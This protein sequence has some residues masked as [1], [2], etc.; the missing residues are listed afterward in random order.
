MTGERSRNEL[1]EAAAQRMVAAERS[2]SPADLLA[3]EEALG[4]LLSQMR[5]D[6]VLRAKVQADI[7][8][9]W[10][11]QW[12][13]GLRPNG[14]TDAIELL[15]SVVAR[16][17]PFRAMC[18]ANLGNALLTRG[19]VEDVDEMVDAFTEAVALTPPGAPQRA[20]YLMNLGAAL[21]ARGRARP[22]SDDV[23]HAIAAIGEAIALE[24]ADD[25]RRA[26][27]RANLA[28]ALR[29]RFDRDHDRGDIDRAVE[30]ARA[31]VE[32]QPSAAT[33]AIL[34]AALLARSTVTGDDVE[35]AEAVRVL[36]GALQAT[37]ESHAYRARRLTGL[38]SAL[39]R[40]AEVHDDPSDLERAEA[41]LLQAAQPASDPRVLRN[42]SSVV[43]LRAQLT[44]DDNLL[45]RGVAVARRIGDDGNLAIALHERG[46]R[47][48][49]LAALD[50]A[51]EVAEA[52]VAAAEPGSREHV[53]A[54]ARLAPIQQTRYL[55]TG[56]GADLDAAVM[57][58]RAAVEG[59][60]NG[61][62]ELPGRLSNLGNALRLR[63]ARTRSERDL[64]D[65]VRILE[66]AVEKAVTGR[67][68]HLSNLGAALQS[69]AELAG[70]DPAAAVPVLLAAVRATPASAPA[71]PRYLSNLGNALVTAGDPDGAV[72]RH[73][74]ALALLPQGH[75]G[76]AV[77][78]GNL[79]AALNA[80]PGAVA[81]DEVTDATRE[82]LA[83]TTVS[84]P[85]RLVAAWRLA[86]LEVRAAGG[87]TRQAAATMRTAVDLA[88]EV[89]W[90][91]AAP[92]DR[93]YTLA[94]FSTLGLDAAATVVDTDPGAAVAMLES[95]RSV[96]WSDQLQHRR[97]E[98]LADR[99]PDLAA[100]LRE[101]ATALDRP[102]AG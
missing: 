8:A 3:A 35:L 77:V 23:D 12:E 37:P 2:G 58:A 25:P 100:R 75:P 70:G 20:P 68:G 89:A 78:W 27:Y 88:R 47:T 55:R 11:R 57:A 63:G 82:V 29:T 73:R 16:P 6:D 26:A 43:I 87:D 60:R 10:R 72:A 13:R 34:G 54:L 98:A 96:G 59:S 42:L 52:V 101:V 71:R 40:R 19:D 79:A 94:R 67:V 17:A 33:A 80:L 5:P 28:D 61:D 51:V 64:D 56:R 18:L 76:R 14:L 1:V 95:G 65:A 66:Q 7:G 84:G 24:Q 30:A 50:E 92:G 15:R 39:R 21:S 46:A 36:V 102:L 9:V 86:D 97:V 69:R 44:G 41:L 74:E 99:S 62:P 45:D 81:L 91:G 85:D 38:A 48:G 49:D 22:A 93:S 31:A 90:I 53:T 4:R 32:A 83:N